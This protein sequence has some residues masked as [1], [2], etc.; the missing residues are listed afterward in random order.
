M[1]GQRPRQVLVAD[2]YGAGKCCVAENMIGVHV[3]V[4]HVANGLRRL[5]ANSRQQPPPLAHAA[6]GIDHC[7]RFRPHDEADI[8]DG[9]F[10]RA[11]HERDGAEMNENT[12]RH[13]R[14]RKGRKPII[15]TYRSRNQR[16]Q[17]DA[18]GRKNG[19]SAPADMVS[20]HSRSD[21]GTHPTEVI[22]AVTCTKLH[23]IIARATQQF[24]EDVFLLRSLKPRH[25]LLQVSG[26]KSVSLT[27]ILTLF[28]G[29][30][31]H[32]TQCPRCHA[33]L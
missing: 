22:F 28:V 15:R 12:G 11:I 21:H 10:I 3:G 20:A 13:F 24:S 4:D 31:G 18:N 26:F 16:G 1:R 8:G 5:R 27:G 33:T 30:A 7:H 19:R 32:P 25:R 23:C 2:E 6:T 29:L 17:T 14:H 9:P